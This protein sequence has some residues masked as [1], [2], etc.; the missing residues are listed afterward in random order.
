VDLLVAAGTLWCL[1]ALVL[2]LPL[3]GAPPPLRR[4]AATLLTVQFVSLLVSGYGVA[5]A[6][7]L[8][9]RDLPLLALALIGTAIWYG[10]RPHRGVRIDARRASGGA[11]APPPR[12]SGDV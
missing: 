8:A 11:R 3:V 4:A 10:L 9:T 2:F 1:F 7:V 12:H 6:W 5:S